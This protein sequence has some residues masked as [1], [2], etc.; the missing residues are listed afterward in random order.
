[1]KTHNAHPLKRAAAIFLQILI[2][3]FGGMVLAALLI[4]PQFEGRNSNANF[5]ETYFT[6][7]FLAYVY[8]A[9]VPFFVALFQAFRALGYIRQN[10]I[11]SQA[12]AAALRIIKY[13]GLL[14]AASTVAAEVYII[15]SARATNDDSA[16][17]VMLGAIVI[18]VSAAA[19]A[20]AAA[21]EKILRKAETK[22]SSFDKVK[23]H[24]S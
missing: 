9:S 21:C 23:T 20:T 2:V 10:N 24:N 3:L 18:V 8:L 17:A 15:I 7:P 6:D 16:G 22:P 5:F 14:V 13:C 19:A 4:G 11:F 1:M 12:G